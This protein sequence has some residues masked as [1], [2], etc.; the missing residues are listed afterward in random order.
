MNDIT[1]S[2]VTEQKVIVQPTTVPMHYPTLGDLGGWATTLI[3]F[4]TLAALVYNFLMRE[5]KRDIKDT[6]KDIEGIKTLHKTEIDGVR[7]SHKNLKAEVAAL[8][9]LRTKDVERIIRLETNLA[10]LE[11]GQERIETRLDT[12]AEDSADARKEIIESIRELRKVAVHA[13]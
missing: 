1:P 3:A 12:M 11:K 7:H 13:S 5:V 10:N 6:V 9:H 2:P 8:D 4:A